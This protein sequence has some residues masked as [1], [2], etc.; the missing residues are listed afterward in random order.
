MI[1]GSTPTTYASNSS[2]TEIRSLL[3]TNYVDPVPDHVLNSS[4]V[5]EMLNKLGDP[6][7]AYFTALEYQDFTNYLDQSFSGIG[8]H[9]DIVTEG[10]VIL[11]VVA[12]SPAE[13]VGLNVGDILIE[14]N[15]KV[16]TGL[17]SEQA[18][19]ILRGPEGSKV[20]IKV[21]RGSAT[22]QFSIIRQK[23]EEA[24]VTGGII[25]GHIGYIRIHTFGSNTSAIFGSKVEELRSRHV[26]DWIIDLRDNP[27]G[28]FN[29]ARD[30]AG[31]FIG[32]NVAVSIKDR[33]NPLQYYKGTNH[34]FVIKEP[35]IFLVNQN[36]AS[37]SEIMSASVKDHRAATIMGTKTYGKGTMQSMFN[38]S[39]GGILKM[40]IARFYSPQGKEINTVGVLPD[41]AVNPDDAGAIA[42]LLFSVS[43]NTVLLDK[44][45]YVQFDSKINQFI[46]ALA[47]AQTP[48]YWRA[49]GE[50]LDSVSS[51]SL[52]EGSGNEWVKITSEGLKA[53][54]PM[55][56]PGYNVVSELSQ[57]PLDKIFTVHFSGKIDWQ[58]VND[59]S[60][61]LIESTSGE[62]VQLKFK[63]I[64]DS[65]LQ[66]LPQTTLKPGSTYWLVLHPSIKDIVGHTML[67]GS[68]A[69]VKTSGTSAQANQY[70]AQSKNSL[71]LVP[72]R[73]YGQ[74]I[75]NKFRN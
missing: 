55:Y 11:S 75:F 19:A 58:S 42:E 70:K 39:D 69:L 34:G 12:G 33:N 41:V 68:L 30:L 49:W 43:G 35:V 73:D 25:D 74:A 4:T 10:V 20:E 52:S 6:H 1:L 53:R 61:E 72:S 38:L 37:A 57:I 15:G 3:T 23:F 46:V 27:G 54:W 9:I 8:I 45:G 44:T 17:S 26:D 32:E 56:Y 5:A 62:R 18:A 14:A 50:V 21:K 29:T 64:S 47:K 36:S 13:T 66:V 22:I 71:T 59:K 2:L 24:T 48:K 31:Y 40:T 7:T 65:E 28:Y 67:Q 16:L 60:V 51:D 63:S